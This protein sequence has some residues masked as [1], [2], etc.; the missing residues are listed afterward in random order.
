M[1]SESFLFEYRNA[2]NQVG[3]AE[4]SE[5]CIRLCGADLWNQLLYYPA[6]PG[7]RDGVVDVFGLTN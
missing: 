6:G 3:Q 4:V 2:A 1:F 5:A 7:R